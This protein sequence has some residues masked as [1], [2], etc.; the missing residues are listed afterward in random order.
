MYVY[1]YMYIVPVLFSLYYFVKLDTKSF[2]INLSS[3]EILL[4][5][6]SIF[7]CASI[8]RPT[9]Y[10]FSVAVVIVSKT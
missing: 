4:F 10:I 9:V 6:P 7:L 8:C 2:I 5:Y 3:F 1:I